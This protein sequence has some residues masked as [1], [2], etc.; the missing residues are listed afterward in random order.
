MP[1][2]LRPIQAV[3]P[4][5]KSR[6]ASWRVLLAG[7]H[8]SCPRCHQVLNVSGHWYAILV[9]Q[10]APFAFFGAAYV[11]GFWHPFWIPALA[12]VGLA[13]AYFVVFNFSVRLTHQSETPTK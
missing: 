11:A 5:C 6:L 9:S 4:Q 10:I 13:A 12:A 8:L 7:T 2:T 3:C 1:V